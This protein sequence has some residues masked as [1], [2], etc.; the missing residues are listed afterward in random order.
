MLDFRVNT[1]LAVCQTLNF[2]QAS[3]ELGLTQPAVSQH[4]K[5]LE[6]FYHTRLCGNKK[7]DCFRNRLFSLPSICFANTW[8][9]TGNS[10]I[11]QAVS[12]Q[13]PSAFMCLTTV[14]GM[15]TGGT[16]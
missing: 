13:V 3:K 11:S 15:G 16:T 14:F 4:I 6:N 7:D 12:S 5:L 1:F 10:L 9:L 2:T 8:P